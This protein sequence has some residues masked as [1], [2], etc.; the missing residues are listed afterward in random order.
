MKT[1]SLLVIFCAVLTF[2]QDPEA[3]LEGVHDLTPSNFKEVIDGTKHAL[4]EFYAPWCGHCKS[5]AAEWGRLGKIVASSSEKSNIVIAKVDANE[6]SGLGSEYGV[7][8]FPTIK[9]FKKGSTTAE[10]YEGGRTAEDF[11]SFLNTKAGARLSIPKD[12]SDVIDLD[13]HNFDK[14]VKDASRDVLVEF[15][16]PWCGH[17]KRLAPDYEKVATAFKNE[18]GVVIAKMDADQAGNKAAAAAYD[19][20]GFPTIKWFPKGDKSGQEYSAG[21]SPEDF[22]N[23]IND[24]VGTHRTVGGLLNEKAGRVET[25]DSLAAEFLESGDQTAALAEIKKVA[26]GG[27]DAQLYVNAAEK[28]IAKGNSYVASERARLQKIIDGRTTTA[29]KLDNMVKR[30]NVLDAFSA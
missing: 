29:D 5:L 19:V 24:K 1:L 7:Q 30:R 28:I 14:I 17:C 22:V 2:A 15:Y 21:R 8:G 9:Y 23:W 20:S 12:A 4:V 6:H 13:G 11:L 25:L 10:E 18:D 26:A 3:H 16:A 27:A